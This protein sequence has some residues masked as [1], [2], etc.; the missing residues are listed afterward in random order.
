MIQK[1]YFKSELALLYMPD[2]S[3][4]TARRALNRAIHNNKELLEKM[5]LT[6]YKNTSKR[7]SP[8]QVK[9]IVIHLGLPDGIF[10]EM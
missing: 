3:L 7:L 6:G 4:E 1:Y 5:S 10:P 2:T 8:L 9:I